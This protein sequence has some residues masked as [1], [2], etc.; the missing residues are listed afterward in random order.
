MKV[1][2]EATNEDT[3]D[4]NNSY[5]F[6]K[7]NSSRSDTRLVSG[8]EASLKDQAVGIDQSFEDHSPMVSRDLRFKKI[9]KKEPPKFT[10]TSKSV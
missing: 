10:K 6:N 5:I 1:V 2:P 8:K 9:L 7:L 3:L 4:V